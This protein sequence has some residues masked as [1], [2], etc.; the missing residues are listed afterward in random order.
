MHC[1]IKKRKK[2]KGVD[3]FKQQENP[4]ASGTAQKLS[5]GKR[6]KNMLASSL[7]MEYHVHTYIVPTDNNFHWFQHSF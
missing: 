3:W 5:T 2:I 4:L 7:Q 6:K 1:P